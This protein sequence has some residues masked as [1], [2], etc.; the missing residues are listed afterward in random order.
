MPYHRAC[1][2]SLPLLV[3]TVPL[4]AQQREEVKPEAAAYE[5]DN[6]AV[7]F[8]S[9][10]EYQEI[11]LNDGRKV[12][13]FSIPVAAQVT[14]GRVRL[15]A[16]LPYMRVKAPGDVVVPSGPLGLPILVDPAGPPEVSTREGIGDLRV[17]AAYQLP[18]PGLNAS[19]SGGVKLPTA[20]TEKGLGTGKTDYRVGADLS[21]TVGAVTPFA[22]VSYT[23]VGDPADY[24]LE[25]TL[26]GHAG[27]AVRLGRSA[28]A[29]VG[30]S[31]EENASGLVDD[32]QR[33]FGGVNAALASGL[34]LGV[35]GS[36]GVNGPADIG[37]G[38]SLGV[39]LN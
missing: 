29:H 25:D 5:G 26:A 11:E 31:Y 32:Q 17:D 37:A 33:V 2:L 15:T 13:K 3:L 35:Y 7:E 30:Y 22:G 21:K 38:I 12:E 24:D 9:G 14:T 4:A 8:F 19:L 6:T 10:A 23:K 16:Q 28:S 36:A 20:S 1:L 39:R 34:S 27:A 18:I